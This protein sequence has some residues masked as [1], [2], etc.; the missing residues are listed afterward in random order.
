MAALLVFWPVLLIT[1]ML[2]RLSGAGPIIYSHRRLGRN[3]EVFGCLKFRT[4]RPDADQVLQDL[5]YFYDRSP[6]LASTVVSNVDL[7]K[8]DLHGQNQVAEDRKAAG[9]K[10]EMQ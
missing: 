2:V 7:R 4:M 8:V 10:G 3:G 1:A 5:K 6:G 9:I